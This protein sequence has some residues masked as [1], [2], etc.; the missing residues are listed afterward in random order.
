MKTKSRQEALEDVVPETR[1]KAKPK[2]AAKRKLSLAFKP[3]LLAK[4]SKTKKPSAIKA[5]VASEEA[6]GQVWKDWESSVLERRQSMFSLTK[7][8]SQQSLSEQAQG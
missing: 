3:S 8:W 5:T 4:K 2:A 7:E 1:S 6:G